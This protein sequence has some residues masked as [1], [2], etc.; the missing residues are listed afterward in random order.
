MSSSVNAPP[1]DVDVVEQILGRRT[2]ADQIMDEFRQADRWGILRYVPPGRMTDARL[3][4]AWIPELEVGIEDDAWHPEAA[5]Y[6]PLYSAT[7]ELVGN[8]AVDLP[9]VEAIKPDW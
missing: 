3:S 6:A 4:A 5:L 1:A 2:P 9:P 7:G 8:M